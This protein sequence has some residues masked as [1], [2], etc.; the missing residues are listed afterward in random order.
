MGRQQTSGSRRSVSV[1]VE[2][3]C[4]RFSHAELSTKF[5]ARVAVERRFF[6]RAT[7][8]AGQLNVELGAWQSIASVGI[9]VENG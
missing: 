5:M 7:G 9:A 6:A 2:L 3:R 8:E 1:D 4:L